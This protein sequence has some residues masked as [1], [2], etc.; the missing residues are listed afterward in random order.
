MH[1]TQ[2]QF[3]LSLKKTPG[4]I[5]LVCDYRR[6]NAVTIPDLYFQ[7]RI[8]EVLEKLAIASLY[9]ILDLASGFHQVPIA[10][11]DKDKTTVISPYGKFRFTVMPFRLHN[12]T[13]S[14]QRMMAGL[15]FCHTDYTLIN[16]DDVAIFNNS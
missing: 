13:A 1:L 10:Q 6:L 5:R 9:K 12:A 11:D 14:F 7:P 3:F 15:L 16:I 8:E 2:A 4:K